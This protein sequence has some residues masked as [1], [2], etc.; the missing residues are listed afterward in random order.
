[1]LLNHFCSSNNIDL[2]V[3]LSDRKQ[4]TADCMFSDFD[5]SF[6]GEAS[7]GSKVLM[8]NCVFS[9]NHLTGTSDAAALLMAKSTLPADGLLEDEQ[10]AT[11]V[12]VILE[13]CKFTSNSSPHTLLVEGG[14]RLQ[15]TVFFSNTPASLDVCAV[16]SGSD[17]FQA[18]SSQ[19]RMSDVRGLE[20]I[21][22]DSAIAREDDP[23]IVQVQ[24]VC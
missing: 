19:C 7:S 2:S 13:D 9:H 10:A 1:M 3:V 16:E 18:P 12:K 20:E 8:V 11:D 24:E 23:W 4:C 21:A 6:V 22:E 15:Q 5:A 14:S 17:T